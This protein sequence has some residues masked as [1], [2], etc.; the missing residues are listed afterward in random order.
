MAR[1]LFWRLGRG[2]LAVPEEQANPDTHRV[3]GESWDGE[4]ISELEDL[5]PKL[6]L[7]IS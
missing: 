3:D 6:A 4:A 7:G 1:N 2:R 5:L